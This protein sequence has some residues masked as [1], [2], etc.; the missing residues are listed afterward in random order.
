MKASF[1]ESERIGKQIASQFNEEAEARGYKIVSYNTNPTAVKRITERE[2]PVERVKVGIDVQYDRKQDEV[3]F[4]FVVDYY[5][6]EV[7]RSEKDKV[8]SKRFETAKEAM[9][10]IEARAN[11]IN[12]F[13]ES[14]D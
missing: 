12:K 11:A 4:T 13:F 7:P 5:Y 8:A 10:F 6:S 3:S 1:T 9:D 14:L 2:S